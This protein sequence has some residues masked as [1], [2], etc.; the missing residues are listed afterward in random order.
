MMSMKNVFGCIYL[1][2]TEDEEASAALSASAMDN[3]RQLQSG[4]VSPMLG[5]RHHSSSPTSS[6]DDIGAEDGDSLHDDDEDELSA[7]LELGSN[8]GMVD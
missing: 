8:S 3:V 5:L 1:S 7:N 6:L 2:Y 4:A